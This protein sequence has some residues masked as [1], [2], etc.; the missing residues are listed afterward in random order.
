MKM[1]V[2]KAEG[3]RYE[4]GDTWVLYYVD[5]VKRGVGEASWGRIGVL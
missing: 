3:A 1:L 2:E 5:V 4:G